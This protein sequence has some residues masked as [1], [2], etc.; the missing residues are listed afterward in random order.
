MYSTLCFL[1]APL[2]SQTPPWD[3]EINVKY[4]QMSLTATEED[5][6]SSERPGSE[7]R[8]RTSA[9][10]G[11]RYWKPEG[12]RKTGQGQLCKTGDEFK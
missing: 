3:L 9:R 2:K 6:G 10:I 4:L 7:L 5:Q 11:H 8:T 1:P 12:V